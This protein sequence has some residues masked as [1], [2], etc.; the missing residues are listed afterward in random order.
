LTIGE[1]AGSAGVDETTL[2]DARRLKVTSVLFRPD[3][4]I[5][6]FEEVDRAAQ[7]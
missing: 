3:G 2:A 4:S 7:T 5:D 6:R 1:E